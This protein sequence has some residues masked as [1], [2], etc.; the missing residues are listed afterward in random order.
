MNHKSETVRWLGWLSFVGKSEWYLVPAAF[1]YLATATADWRNAGHRAR[2]WLLKLFGQAAFLFAAVAIT[3]LTVDLVKIV[4]GRARPWRYGEFGA[5]HFE[6]LVVNKYFT[7]FPS[8][9]STTL[10]TVAVVAMIW[11]PRYWLPIL[12]TGFL[13]SMLRVAATAHFPSDVTAGYLYGAVLTVLMAR[14]LAARRVGFAPRRGKI[15]PA[16]IGWRKKSSK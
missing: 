16:A 7:S 11:F 8:G 2:A 4:V 14:F 10:G 5:Y 9:H 6:P 13:C 1:L 15:L 12:L 3:G